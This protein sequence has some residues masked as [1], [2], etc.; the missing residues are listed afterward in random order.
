LLTC[1]RKQV[2]RYDRGPDITFKRTQ[3]F[4]G[5]ARHSKTAFNPGN[6][7][8]NTG[9][10]STQAVVNPLTATHVINFQAA[11]FG[12]TDIFDL[13]FFGFI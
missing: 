11:L 1:E 7:G 12:E 13:F 8:F 4:P 2:G 5:A 9:A 3:S 10:E 6:S